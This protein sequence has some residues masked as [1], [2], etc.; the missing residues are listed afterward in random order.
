MWRLRPRPSRLVAF[1]KRYR[2]AWAWITMALYL[3]AVP[4]TIW[5]FPAN[6]LWL[7]LIVL[8][9]GF[10]ASLTTLGDL[11]VNAEDS[12]RLD[13]ADGTQEPAE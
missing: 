3:I 8:F 4:F 2:V 6:N 1:I 10:T 13:K 7:A 11:L 9:S 12:E 5:R